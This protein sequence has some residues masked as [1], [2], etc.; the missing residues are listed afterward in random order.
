MEVAL[1][2]TI[3]NADVLEITRKNGAKQEVAQ[4][5]VD[6]ESGEGFF[7]ITDS[8]N[9]NKLDLIP[10]HYEESEEELFL[11]IYG[12]NESATSKLSLFIE[13]SSDF[14]EIESK[15]EYSTGEVVI[16]SDVTCSMSM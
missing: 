1:I 14:S 11:K 15:L 3:L 6:L 7:K 5:E 2:R 16:E 10:Y 13:N 9:G 4:I 8:S 12:Q